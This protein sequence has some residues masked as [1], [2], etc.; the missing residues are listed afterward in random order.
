MALWGNYLN[1]GNTKK[2]ALKLTCLRKIIQLGSKVTIIA[3]CSV[4]NIW[5]SLFDVISKL[6]SFWWDKDLWFWVLGKSS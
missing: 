1:N 4:S 2:E 3:H 5:E 6:A